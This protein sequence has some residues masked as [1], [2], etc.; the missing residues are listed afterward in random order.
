MAK[1]V[2]TTKKAPRNAVKKAA[3]KKAVAKK[4][5]KAAAARSKPARGSD[6]LRVAASLTA[7][8]VQASIAWYC[9][10]LGFM[11]VER[12]QHNG[13][14]VGAEIGS[15]DVRVYLNQDDWKQGRDR[16]KGQGV[17]LFVTTGPDIDGYAKAIKARGGVLDAEPIDEWGMRAFSVH[18]PDGYKLTFMTPLPKSRGSR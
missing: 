11:V 9:D 16:M 4:T 10:V 8:D 18:D 1:K 13:Q 3:A 15:G 7:S 5:T 17:R 14:V 6:L 12:W 2:K